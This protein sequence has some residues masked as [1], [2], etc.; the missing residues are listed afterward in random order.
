MV[1]LDIRG[2]VYPQPEG[3]GEAVPEQRRQRLPARLEGRRGL[4][5]PG[6]RHHG[7]HCPP[8]SPDALLQVLSLL[9][10]LHG[11]FGDILA[12]VLT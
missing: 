1:L 6:P 8:R 3:V 11:E 9:L 10:R 12:S 7:L 5:H 4:L 2:R